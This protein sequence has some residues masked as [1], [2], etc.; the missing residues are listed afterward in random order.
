MDPSQIYKYFLELV[1]I[2]GLYCKS[3]AR[4]ATS[5]NEIEKVIEIVVFLW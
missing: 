3:W 5:E 2:S 4:L 1:H